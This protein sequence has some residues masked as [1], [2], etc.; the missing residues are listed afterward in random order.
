MRATSDYFSHFPRATRVPPRQ[1]A[2]LLSEARNG[3]RAEGSFYLEL[4][5]SGIETILYIHE[6]MSSK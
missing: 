3:R 2:E 1:L 5:N 6:F 4:I